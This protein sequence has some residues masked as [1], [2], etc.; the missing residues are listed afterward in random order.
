MV[1]RCVMTTCD[2]KFAES[3]PAKAKTPRASRT[4]AALRRLQSD[5]VED[6][7]HMDENGDGRV[8]R[9]EAKK[10]REKEASPQREAPHTVSALKAKLTQMGLSTKGV[11]S[12]L[13]NR[14]SDGEHPLRPYGEDAFCAFVAGFAWRG[15]RPAR[16]VPRR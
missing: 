11:K 4:P 13:M 12:E 10:Y 2:L 7:S 3:T 1:L 15:E 8:M 6:L 14:L 5:G 16:N 9:S